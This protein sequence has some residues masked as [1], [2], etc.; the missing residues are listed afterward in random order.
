MANLEHLEALAEETNKYLGEDK[1]PKTECQCLE[2]IWYLQAILEGKVE[3]ELQIVG[4]KGHDH[5][6]LKLND[7]VLDPQIHRYIKDKG[8]VFKQNQYPLIKNE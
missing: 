8:H 3:Y 4:I 2:A 7:I 1:F 5:L 6:S